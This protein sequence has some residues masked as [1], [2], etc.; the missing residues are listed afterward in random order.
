MDMI[1]VTD[2]LQKRLWAVTAFRQ[3]V[4]WFYRTGCRKPCL[5]RSQL[6]FIPDLGDLYSDKPR[7]PYPVPPS[8]SVHISQT[9]LQAFKSGHQLKP[10]S[11]C[12]IS[13]RLLRG[14]PSF[15]HLDYSTSTS[16]SYSTLPSSSRHSI[17]AP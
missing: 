8:V 6:F 17:P 4:P 12:C 14:H 1:K 13:P 3:L 9:P 10:A 7:Q 2:S 11:M 5:S 16:F 15:R